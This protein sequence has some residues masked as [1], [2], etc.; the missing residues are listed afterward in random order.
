MQAK[1]IRSI[2]MMTFGAISLASSNLDEDSKAPARQPCRRRY[3]A[4]D[5]RPTTRIDGE[6]R[7]LSFDTSFATNAKE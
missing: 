7:G 3:R 1:V 4:R 2:N 5:Q 6:G